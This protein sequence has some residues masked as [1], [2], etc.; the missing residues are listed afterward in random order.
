MRSEKPSHSAETRTTHM[1]SHPKSQIPNPKSQI[2]NVGLRLADTARRDPDGVAVVEPAGRDRAGKGQYRHVS[3]RELDEDSSRIAAGLLACGVKPGSR[4]VLL[5]P[6][7]ID[8]VSLVFALFKAGMVTVLIDPG[9]GRRNLIRCLEE[10]EPDG[11]VAISVAQAVRTILRRRFR[12]AVHNV[13]VG[14]RWFWSGATLRQLRRH[15]ATDFQPAST[16]AED[17]AAII[18]TTG[19]TGP[20]KGVLYGHGNFAWQV[21]ELRELYGVQPGEKDLSGFPLFALFNAAMGVTAVIPEM[22]FTRPAQADP[23]KIVEAANDWQVTQ[24]FGSPALWN[25]VGRYCEDNDVR[26]PTLRRVTS[27]GAPVPPHVLRRMKQ[28]IHP[29]GDIHTPYGATEALPVASISATEVLSET[30]DR[31]QEGAG[32]CVGRRFPGITWKVIRIRDEAIDRIEDVEELP[33]GEI[34]ELLVSGPVVTRRYVTRT[35]A[36]PL[37]KILDGDTVWHRMGDV[38]YLDEQDRFWFCGRKAHRLLTE[39]GPMYSVPCEAIFNRHKRVYRSALVGIGE[40]G[41][42]RPV[43]IVET[44]PEHRVSSPAEE[45]AL[46][47]ELRTLARNQASTRAIKDFLVHPSMPVDI[48]HNA[49]IFREKLAVWAQQQRG[50]ASR[51]PS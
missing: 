29:E 14:R 33:Q 10:A 46:L 34:G 23:R 25:V 38:G 12:S 9:M 31:S 40:R 39:D 19:S 27:A 7:G 32:T 16:R 8:F 13:T 51:G 45:Q 28:A 20:P 3:F 43:L 1:S 24:A 44:W 17:P 2:V 18:F 26:I 37:H 41:R 5:V 4:L 35:D 42:Q 21:D 22:D 49:K 6:P 36:N 50:I 11:L 48:R 47:A 30:A 15:S